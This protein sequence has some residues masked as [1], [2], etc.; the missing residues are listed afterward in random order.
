[1]GL[2]GAGRHLGAGVDHDSHA[3]FPAPIETFAAGRD[4]LQP[5]PSTARARTT[6]GWAGTCWPRCSAW[7]LGFG[8]A[9]LVGIPAGLPDWSISP[10]SAACSTPLISLLQAGVS[11][12]AWLPIGLLV[13]KGAN[14][15]AIWTIF[16]CSIW[17][18]I[19]N[20]AVGVQRVPSGL[21]E[22]GARCSS[23]ERV[24]DHHQDPVSCRVALHA[25]RRATGR[26]YGLAGDRGRRDA[27]GGR[28]HRLLGV[29]RVEQPQ[30]AATS[31]S[32]SS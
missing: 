19:I 15:A 8:L 28:R 10:S 5:T 16:I 23:S 17:P 9:A 13:F 25:H 7:A 32:P 22:C 12:L 4:D 14:P 27:H 30:C 1:M 18:M 2:G 20:T 6:R 24:E 29:G 3:R 21:H 11:P 26:G 31:S